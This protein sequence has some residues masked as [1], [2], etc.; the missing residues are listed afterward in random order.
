MSPQ[1]QFTPLVRLQRKCK[2]WQLT[3]TFGIT[4][5][6][7]VVLASTPVQ[8]GGAALL[9]PHGAVAVKV[10]VTVAG[11]GAVRLAVARTTV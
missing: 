11:D 3:L 4:R 9:P 7:A 2:I 1:N 10:R 8:S 5:P 6:V